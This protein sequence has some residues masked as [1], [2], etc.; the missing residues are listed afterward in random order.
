MFCKYCGAQIKDTAAFCKKCGA[1]QPVILSTDKIKEK[2]DNEEMNKQEIGSNTYTDVSTASV[3]KEPNND[4]GQS[5]NKKRKINWPARIIIGVILIMIGLGLA[6][7]DAIFYGGLFNGNGALSESDCKS[8][9]RG[10]MHDVH[11]AS[12]E[13]FADGGNNI[14]SESFDETEVNLNDTGATIHFKGYRLSDGFYLGIPNTIQLDKK[15][16]VVSCEW[17]RLGINDEQDDISSTNSNPNSEQNSSTEHLTGED[18]PDENSST[19]PGHQNPSENT[20]PPDTQQPPSQTPDRDFKKEAKE[21]FDALDIEITRFSVNDHEDTGF[22]S[23]SVKETKEY[24]W[25]DW[26]DSGWN[27]TIDVKVNDYK[28]SYSSSYGEIVPLKPGNNTAIVEVKD[29]YGNSRTVKKSVVFE[30]EEPMPYP[31]RLSGSSMIFNSGIGF[32]GASSWY[33]GPDKLTFTV[34]GKKVVPRFEN[35]SDAVI[36]VD[37]SKEK[38]FTVVVTNKYGISNSHTVTFP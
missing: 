9:V 11:K 7:K 5:G 13:P 26:P 32:G 18:Y 21:L 16:K 33:N 24:I 38:T 31:P 36:D 3:K 30:P 8:I 12:M 10:H 14:T 19:T 4:I 20:S 22:I 17:C 34:N 2:S 6:F 23:V 35:Y 15:G 28:T 27:Y 1:K 25:L 29:N 37:L